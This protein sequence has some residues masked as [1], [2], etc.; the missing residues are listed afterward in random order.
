[1]AKKMPHKLA[2]AHAYWRLAAK[3]F[4]AGNARDFRRY[5]DLAEK[6][7]REHQRQQEHL[8]RWKAN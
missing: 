6:R 5:T 3:A 4:K 1:M 7:Y 2:Q 8:A